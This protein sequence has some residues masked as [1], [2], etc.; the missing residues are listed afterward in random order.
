MANKDW[1]NLET[2]SGIYEEG[3][4][5]NQKVSYGFAH[6]NLSIIKPALK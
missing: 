4:K 3:D 6:N 5:E 2:G 1:N